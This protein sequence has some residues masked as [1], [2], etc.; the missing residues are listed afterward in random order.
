MTSA[1]ILAGGLGTRCA[2]RFPI[3][4]SRW[5]RSPAGRSW[6]TRWTTGSARASTTSCSRSAIARSRSATISAIATAACRSTTRS[7]RAARHRRRADARGEASCARRDPALLLNGD[8]YFD[9][10]LAA[11]AER[12]TSL[13]ADWCLALFRHDDAARY[14]GVALSP[15]RSDHGLARALRATCQRRRLLV[16]ARGARRRALGPGQA[17]SLED[18]LLPRLLARGQRLRRP[19]RRGRLHRHR[20]AARLPPRRQRAATHRPISEQRHAIAR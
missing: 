10:S 7:S 9:V 8:T 16:S 12:A 14:M 18:D 6:R 19:R 15:R 1:I 17:A 3:C 13:D 2:T 20:R 4:P 11:L 5:R